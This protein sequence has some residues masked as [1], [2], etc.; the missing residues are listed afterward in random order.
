MQDVTAEVR[1]LRFFD[2]NDLGQPQRLGAVRILLKVDELADEIGD[3]RIHQSVMASLCGLDKL[4][5]SRCVTD[6]LSYG[7]IEIDKSAWPWLWSI[8][9]MAATRRQGGAA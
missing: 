8:G 5:A 2:A 4:T 3:L 9:P 7:L 1:P 6:L